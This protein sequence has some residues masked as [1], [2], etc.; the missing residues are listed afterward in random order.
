VG[1]SAHIR[2]SKDQCFWALKEIRKRCPF[3]RKGLDA[4]NGQEFIL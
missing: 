1:R 2:K 4:D 3:V